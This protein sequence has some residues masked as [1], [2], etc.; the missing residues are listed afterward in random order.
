MTRP[1]FSKDRISHFEIFGRHADEALTLLKTRLREG[2]AVDIQDLFARF[3]LDSATEFLFG[4]CVHILRKGLPY[5]PNLASSKFAQRKDTDQ[6][7]LFA[8]AF[9]NAQLTAAYRTRVGDLW[10]L[11]EMRKDMTKDDIKIVNAFIEPILQETIAKRGTPQDFAASKKIEEGETLLDHLITYA[12][13]KFLS[14]V[15]NSSR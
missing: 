11:S 10:P 6:A 7:S 12:K 2:Y 13:G 5:S 1:F 8:R 4:H 15:R 9:A 3:T 14:F